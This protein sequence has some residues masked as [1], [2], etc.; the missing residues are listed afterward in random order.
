V[1]Y[2]IAVTSTNDDGRA[3]REALVLRLS[4][5]DASCAGA[6]GELVFDGSLAG[7]R[8]GDPKPGAQAGDRIL[9]AAGRET[10]CVTVILPV[11]TT[12]ALQSAETTVTF[13]IHAER[14]GV[15]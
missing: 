2:S 14:A 7:A 13:A 5:A 3:L 12:D 4:T 10:L 6:S 9:E 11:G 15:D 1:R 8:L